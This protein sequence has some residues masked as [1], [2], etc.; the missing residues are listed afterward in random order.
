MHR[1]FVHGVVYIVGGLGHQN[2]KEGLFDRSH[3]AQA[4]FA[5]LFH[6]LLHLVSG[7][8]EALPKLEVDNRHGGAEAQGYLVASAH[9]N[10]AV[11]GTFLLR[12]GS[13]RD[14]RDKGRTGS[15]VQLLYVI[16]D[17]LHQAGH[18]PGH[19]AT[20]AR[21]TL[22]VRAEVYLLLL[23]GVT[24]HAGGI[25]LREEG[26]VGTLLRIFHA[27]NL[28]IGHLYGS[29]FRKGDFD[30]VFQGENQGGVSGGTLISLELCPRLTGD[31]QRKQ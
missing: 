3:R 7:E 17:G 6:G 22:I 24:I 16:H 10:G 21:A 19:T 31:Y 1:I 23:D 26:P 20:G 25:D 12:I 30:G 5:G 8:T 2:G 4:G 29:V 27:L 15:L 28:H 9:F 18:H 11:S 13:G 14:V